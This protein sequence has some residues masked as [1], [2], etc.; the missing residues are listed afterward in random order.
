MSSPNCFISLIYNWWKFIREP[1][2]NTHS[3]A[4][5]SQP[6]VELTVMT[7]TEEHCFLAN[8]CVKL[9]FSFAFL[10]WLLFCAWRDRRR[11][12]WGLWVQWN[13]SCWRL[14][15]SCRTFSALHRGRRA[16]T[17]RTFRWNADFCP[18]RIERQREIMFWMAPSTT[19]L[20]YLRNASQRVA[21]TSRTVNHNLWC[22]LSWM[23]LQ[24]RMQRMAKEWYGA[25]SVLPLWFSIFGECMP[26]EIAQVEYS[27]RS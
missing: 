3:I 11:K 7:F 26:E 9:G 16:M 4:N 27:I 23:V 25:M 2:D 1:L 10:T 20:R 21:D 8:T 24:C 6:H 5:Q 13:Q 14:W 12:W 15:L 19:M 22:F 17:F 18:I